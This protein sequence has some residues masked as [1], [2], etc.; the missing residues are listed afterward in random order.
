MSYDYLGFLHVV[1]RKKVQWLQ[2]CKI[3]LKEL[4]PQRQLSREMMQINSK[5]LNTESIHNNNGQK[6]ETNLNG[7]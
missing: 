2:L 4:K 7:F 1:F 6:R 3:M 5:F